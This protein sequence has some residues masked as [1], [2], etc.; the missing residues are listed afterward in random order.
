[1]FKSILLGRSLASGITDCLS[2]LAVFAV[3][4]WMVGA[5]TEML[6][7]QS[8]EAN[9]RRKIENHRSRAKADPAKSG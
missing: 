3:L 8:L 7:R 6:I 1:L 5:L 2:L 4:G 9:F